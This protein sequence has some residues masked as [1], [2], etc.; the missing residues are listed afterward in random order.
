MQCSWLAPSH[1]DEASC[2]AGLGALVVIALHAS[3][4]ADIAD[5]R[6]GGAK[7]RLHALGR[8]GSRG[9][10]RCVIH[11]EY[12]SWTRRAFGLSARCSR[13]VALFT[14]GSVPVAARLAALLRCSSIRVA[15]SATA[16]ARLISCQVRVGLRMD[17]GLKN[18]LAREFEQR[19][20]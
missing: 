3:F 13:F 5:E 14:I 20:G 12:L 1:D 19:V 7:H 8:A 9:V 17:A 10:G 2:L 15:I 11:S 4:A 18:V 6:H 16:S